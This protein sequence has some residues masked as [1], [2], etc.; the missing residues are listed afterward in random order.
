[1]VLISK[2]NRRVIY[3]HVF[4]E[5]VIAVKHDPNAC[6]HN[7][8]ELEEI[9]NLHVMMV[10]RSLCSRNYVT[11]K[12]NWQW[13]YYFLTN[14]GIDYLRDVLN[15]PAQVFPST[16][17]KQRPSRP[18]LAGADTAAGDSGKGGGWGKGKG[19]GKWSDGD[20]YGKGY[21]KGE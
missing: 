2:K 15:L 9:P 13:H 5:G 19:K 10:M 14:E 1:M 4:K 20:G 16:L 21:G 12:F 8:P 6:R 3:E 11:E 18:A 7:E 17:T